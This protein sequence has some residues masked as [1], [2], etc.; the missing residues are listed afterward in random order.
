MPRR[1]YPL[2][3]LRA[4]EAAARN[5]SF[6]KTAEELSVSA[7]AV[8]QQVKVLEE[9]LGQPLFRRQPKGLLLTESGE[10]LLSEL[11]A[12]FLTLDKAIARVIDND[13]RSSLTLSVAPTFAV[14]WLIPNLQQF[15]VL[16][17]DIDVRISTSLG[18]VDFQRDDFD[19]AI[20]LG[21]GKWF[22]MD[23]IKLFDESVTPMCSPRLLEGPDAIRTPNDLNKHTLLHNHSMD[24]DPDAPTWKTWLTAAGVDGVDADRGTHYSLPDHGLQASIDGAGVVL[25]WE[26]LAEKDVAA[27]RLVAPFDLSLSLGN[28]FYLTYPESYSRRPHIIAFREWLMKELAL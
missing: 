13:A 12:V 7:A 5:L 23:N 11:G 28:S 3:A 22:G 2:N 21:G 18:L 4:F 10:L 16:Y 27:G 8:S 20:R 1:N 19:A 9:F 6:V 14:M 24:Y 25:G 26:R 15:D 17:P